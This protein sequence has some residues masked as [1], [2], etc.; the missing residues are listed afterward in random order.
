MGSPLHYPADDANTPGNRGW[1]GTVLVALG[2]LWAGPNTIVAVAI[3]LLLGGRFETVNGVIEIEGSR[4][5]AVLSRL[6]VPAAAMTVGHVVF[7][8]DRGWLQVTR[9]HERVHVAQYAKWGPFFI[10]AYLFLSA[11]LYAQGKDGYRGNPF[12]IEAYAVDEPKD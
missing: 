10:P 2:Y 4:I 9:N 7:G 3:G 1:L 5:A 12:E 6:P 8:R 11:W